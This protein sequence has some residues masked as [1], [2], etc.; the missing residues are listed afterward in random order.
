[1]MHTL[2]L[3]GP[4]SARA[5]W[6]CTTMLTNV[7]VQDGPLALA[8]RHGP[9]SKTPE[10]SMGMCMPRSWGNPSIIAAALHALTGWDGVAYLDGGGDVGGANAEGGYTEDATAGF[11]PVCALGH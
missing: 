4:L 3:A 2:G 10:T 11:S 9:R 6:I 1:M 8:P 7:S 5:S